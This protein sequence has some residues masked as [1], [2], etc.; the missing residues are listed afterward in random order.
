MKTSC[1]ALLCT[2]IVLSQILHTDCERQKERKKEQTHT[3]K[4]GRQESRSSPQDGKGQRDRGQ[5]VAQKGKFISK[6]K[7]PCTWML[8]ESETST[9]KI[10]CKKE[11][12]N[13]SCVFSGNPSTCPQFS[14][15]RNV[16]WKQITRSLKK[17]KNICEDPKDILKSSVCRKGP[18]SA[19]LRQLSSHNSKQDNPVLHGI[20]ASSATIFSNASKNLPERGSS[21]CVEDVDYIDQRKVAEEYCSELWLSL[22]HFFVA[23]LQDKKC[24]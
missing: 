24:K 11:D 18:A 23:M 7:S 13:I 3:G 14:E 16:F 12:H 9:L 2:L 5:K 17:K 22:C 20:K 10:D 21:D 6:E 15:N 19:H 8:S 4:V 1:L